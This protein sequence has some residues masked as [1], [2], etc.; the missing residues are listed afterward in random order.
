MVVPSAMIEIELSFSTNLSWRTPG[1]ITAT[2]LPSAKIR[3]G[4]TRILWPLKFN[5]GSATWRRDAAAS[6]FV[7]WPYSE[8]ASIQRPLGVTN[9][10]FH[11]GGG[12][13]CCGWLHSRIP[14][15]QYGNQAN[16]RCLE[17]AHR[18]CHLK[19]CPRTA[20]A[21]GGAM[22]TMRRIASSATLRNGD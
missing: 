16:C 21:T 11:C 4:S 5:S 7:T 15:G 20:R 2:S 13:L 17:V 6:G 19:F 12:A 22:C 8:T 1:S 9:L 10:V 3:S 14:R 18:W